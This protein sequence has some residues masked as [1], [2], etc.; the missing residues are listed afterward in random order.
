M[1]RATWNVVLDMVQ[2]FRWVC[3]PGEAEL[4]A[5]GRP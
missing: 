1:V 5:L 2:A 4:S 3:E